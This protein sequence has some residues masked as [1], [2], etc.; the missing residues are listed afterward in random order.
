[1]RIAILGAGFAGL[2]VSWNLLRYKL[3]SISIDL[4]DPEPIGK[5]VSGQSSGLL[6]TYSGKEARKSWR[7]EEC[8]HETHRLIT[9]ASTGINEPIVLSKG[10]LRP[11]LTDEQCL[12][13]KRCAETHEDTEWWDAKRCIRE[14]PGLAVPEENGG[15]YIKSGI[16]IDTQSYLQGL[17]QR[18]AKMGVQYSKSTA[19]RPA[20]LAKY[21]CVLIATGPVTK[22]FPG[23]EKL[24]ITPVKGQ[25]LELEW[26]QEVP[27]PPISLISQKYLVMSRDRKRCMVGATFERDFTSPKADIQE[28]AA[29]IMP[30]IISFFPALEGAKILRCRS[31]FR[32]S[33]PSHL[34]L[35]GR[36]SDK[37]YFFTGL[38]SKGL[39]YHAWVGK[40]VAR[41]ILT[42]DPQH[43]PHDIYY[44]LT[45]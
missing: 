13:F 29:E 2:S 24:P 31:G 4:F 23:L 18:I 30:N 5:G 9:E 45:Q 33:T 7:A 16:T 8:L 32:A 25:L 39:L 43:F 15:L 1:M 44:E 38:G 26:P 21:D 12:A 42:Q 27:P 28:A 17:W 36:I 40:R 10:I 34:P 35:V 11:A 22:N 19:I 41:A 6:H 20:E 3:G 37:I 14:V